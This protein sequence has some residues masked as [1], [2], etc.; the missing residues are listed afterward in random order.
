MY[1]TEA[2]VIDLLT[3][4]ANFK[5][6]FKKCNACVGEAVCVLAYLLDDGAKLGY[7]AYTANEMNTDAHVY[8]KT[9]PVVINALI[10]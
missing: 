1:F 3:V 2:K 4:S 5:V 9:R 6:M 7:E 10:L 8:Y